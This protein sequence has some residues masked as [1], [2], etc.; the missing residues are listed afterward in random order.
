MKLEKKIILVEV[1]QIVYVFSYMWILTFK[2]F[3]DIQNL[4]NH[5]Y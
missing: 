3:I 2:I 5:R 4:Y 1:I